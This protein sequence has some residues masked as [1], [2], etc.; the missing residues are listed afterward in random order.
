MRNDKISD[1]YR[2]EKFNK[3]FNGNFFRKITTDCTVPI[4]YK[5]DRITLLRKVYESLEDGTYRPKSPREYIY[6]NKGQF[7]PRITVVFHPEDEIVYFFCVKILEEKIAKNRVKNTFGGW[8]LGNAIR[9]IEAGEISAAE[10]GITSHNPFLWVKNWQEFQKIIYKFCDS[11]DYKYAIKLD[12][13][14][15]YD[16]IIISLLKDNMLA[17]VKTKKENY[18]VRLLIY[19][20]SYWNQGI[21]PYNPQIVGI[22]QHELS[23]SSRLLANFYLQ[24]YDSEMQKICSKL[25]GKY[26]RYAD[27]QIIFLKNKS[28]RQKITY[29][30]GLQLS[31]L[32]LSINAKK[33]AIFNMQGLIE[34]YAVPIFNHIENDE[35]NNAC[36]LYFDWK[37]ANKDFR[38]HSV[39][40]K[41]FGLKYD[42]FKGIN[43][44][45]KNELLKTVLSENFLMGQNARFFGKLHEKLTSDEKNIFFRK[46][47]KIQESNVFNSFYYNLKKFIENIPDNS[48]AVKKIKRQLKRKK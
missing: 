46:L 9:E 8:V 15:F 47:G 14:N 27:D 48:S 38:D 32:G 42:N 7:V 5:I 13:A 36:D 45:H 19:F 33:V 22:P 11:N 18:A 4:S 6:I 21:N 17:R 2:L 39:L 12:I 3:I 20:L 29:E 44:H 34:H 1:F 23:D 31:K 10:Y 30:A 16:N 25:K 40:K 24:E 41:I 26:T 35:L 43:E 37:K 28:D